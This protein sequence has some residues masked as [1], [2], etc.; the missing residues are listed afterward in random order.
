MPTTEHHKFL[1]LPEV[2]MR[3]PYSRSHLWRMERDG[4]FPK[5]VKLGPNRVGWLAGE[6]DAWIN[7]RIIERDTR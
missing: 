5:R 2:L 6:I 3:V 4:K 7:S 1:R